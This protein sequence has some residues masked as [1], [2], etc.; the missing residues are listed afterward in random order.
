M[1]PELPR[2]IGEDDLGAIPDLVK[3][4]QAF[5]ASIDWAAAGW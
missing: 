2:E 5:A 3:I 4:G 1:N